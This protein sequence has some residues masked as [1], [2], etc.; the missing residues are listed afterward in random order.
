[1]NTPIITYEH[2]NLNLFDSE[3]A[4]C[5]SIES[6][7]I[8]SIRVFDATGM[9]NFLME[10]GEGKTKKS[11]F[12]FDVI[13]IENI[14][15]VEVDQARG[16]IDSRKELRHFLVEYF[17]DKDFEGTVKMELSELVALLEMYLSRPKEQSG[18]DPD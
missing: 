6:P 9:E 10:K 4:M 1:M 11:S 13:H 2:G 7:D 18:T 14:N 12:F 5:R 8:E 17:E 3:A 15:P 16:C